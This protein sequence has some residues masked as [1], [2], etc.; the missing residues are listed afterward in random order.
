MNLQKYRSAVAVAGMLAI[1]L[2]GSPV[3]MAQDHQHHNHD[4]VP[5]MDSDGKRLDSYQVKHDMDAETLA[6]LRDQ[7]ALYRGMTEI[8]QCRARSVS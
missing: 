1:M 2:V 4:V 5:E 6:A 7:I 3:G 8:S